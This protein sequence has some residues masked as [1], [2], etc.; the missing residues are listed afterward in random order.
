MR[1]FGSALAFAWTV[2]VCAAQES[3]QQ[4]AHFH[5][6]HLNV[7][8]PAAAIDFHTSK[9]DC[10]KAK[11]AGLSD[12]VWSQNSWLLF[13]KVVYQGCLPRLFTK[14]VYQGGCATEVR[15][16]VHDLAHWLGRRGREG[17]LSG[18]SIAVR[19]SPRRSPT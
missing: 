17:H 15:D 19:S 14:V 6:V 7:T 12:A 18:S 10:E 4:L 1:F 11:F 16:H 5:H 8:D 2:W 9:F 3:P 13:T